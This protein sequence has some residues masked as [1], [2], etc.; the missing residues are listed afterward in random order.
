[1]ARKSKMRGKFMRHLRI[2]AR[3]DGA[4]LVLMDQGRFRHLS[5]DWILQKHKD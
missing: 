1:M 3:V 4:L 2:F 5:A